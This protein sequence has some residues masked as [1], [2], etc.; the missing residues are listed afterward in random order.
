MTTSVLSL[1]GALGVIIA[2]GIAVYWWE[3]W[4]LR[5]VPF[6][7]ATTF[8]VVWFGGTAE[9]FA[10]LATRTLIVNTATGIMLLFAWLQIRE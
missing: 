10:D 6:L 8:S 3:R 5:L 1:V 4:I 9:S 7:Y 2:I